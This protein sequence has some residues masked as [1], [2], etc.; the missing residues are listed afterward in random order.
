MREVPT[1]VL[2]LAVV[3]AGCTAPDPDAGSAPD[4]GTGRADRSE[5][6]V[7]DR[8]DL[9]ACGRAEATFLAPASDFDGLPDGF[10]LESAGPGLA[11]IVVTV[12]DCD[13]GGRAARLV[14]PMVAVVPPEALRAASADLHGIQLGIVTDHAGLLATLEAWGLGELELAGMAFDRTDAPSTA[15][16]RVRA[17]PDFLL[18]VDAA[19]EAAQPTS[20]RRVFGLALTEEGAVVTGA[21]D[22]DLGDAP[23][24]GGGAT[25]SFIVQPTGADLPYHQAGPG[26]VAV[27]PADASL[28][29][30]AA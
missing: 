24:L 10:G 19:G 17:E 11:R 18:T 12:L 3:L 15:E 23:H 5:P 2:V 30:V 9:A 16:V 26:T 1:L 6:L 4:A 13:L 20:A 8:L 28:H 27:A 21:L 25:A 7:A 14:L 29:R 22:L